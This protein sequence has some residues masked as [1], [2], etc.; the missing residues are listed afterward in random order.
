MYFKNYYK[1]WTTI[2][3]VTVDAIEKAYRM[4]TL[5]Y[6]MVRN[7]NDN[8]S[9]TKLKEINEAI[10]YWECRKREEYDL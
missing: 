5:T 10:L 4:P 9:A 1:M 3:T 7:I 8:A 6:Y 2:K